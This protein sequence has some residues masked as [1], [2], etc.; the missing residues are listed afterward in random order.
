MSFIAG[1]LSATKCHADYIMKLIS[2]VAQK[3]TWLKLKIK[4]VY[5]FMDDCSSLKFIKCDLKIEVI[6]IV[7]KLF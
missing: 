6:K 3:F 1:F 5:Y 2:F 4:K 7:D